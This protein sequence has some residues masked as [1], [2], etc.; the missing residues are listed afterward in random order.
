MKIKHIET[1]RVSDPADVIWVRIHTDAGLIGLGETWYAS[2]TVESAVHDHFAPLIVGRDPFAIERHWLNMFRLSDHAGYG[3]AELRAISAIDMALWDIKGQ[4]AGVPVYELL[5]GAVRKKIRV[6]ATGAPFV[7]AGDLARELIDDGMIAMKMGPTISVATPSEG[8]YLSS[9]DLDLALQPFRDVRDAVGD[10]IKIANDGHGKWALPVAIQIAKAME[11]L[12]IMWQEDLM[13]LLNP[14]ALRQLQDATNTPV[15]ISERLLTRWQLREFIENGSAQIVMPDLIWTG[16]ISETHR[17]AVMASA[18]QV[19][20]APHDATGPVNIFACAQICMNSPNAMIMEHVRPY[21]YGWYG[22]FVD[23]LPPIE[24]GWLSAPQNPGIGTRLRPEV[25]ERS[26]CETR[27]TDE[28][29]AIPGMNDEGWTGR[30]NFSDGMW[31]EMEEIMKFRSL[32]YSDAGRLS[33]GE[34]DAPTG[35]PGGGIATWYK[36][37]EPDKGGDE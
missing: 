17:I 24:H 16:G 31:A 33:P 20:V 25:L 18:H 32:G 5:G 2:K 26:D 21:L 12:D 7:G 34:G 11:P 30:E 37:G 13:P 36:D 6:Y 10:G 35:G 1:V 15:C 27:V 8:Q 14:D 23:P 9:K 19:P 4:A 22:D 29:V 3:G 28:S